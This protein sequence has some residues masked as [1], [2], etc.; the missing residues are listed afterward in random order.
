MTRIIF[1]NDYLSPNQVDID[2]TDEY[3][4][5]VKQGFSIE[6]LSFE[7]LEKGDIVK[8]CQKIK[9]AGSIEKACYR[10]WM[11]TPDLYELLYNHLINKNIQLINTPEEYLNCHYFPYY[12]PIIKDLTAESIWV[13]VNNEV[14][15][16]E[17]FAALNIF[18]N[19]AVILKDYVKSEKHYWHTACYIPNASDKENVKKISNTFLSLRGN[20]L[21]KGLVYREFL[22]LAH[23]VNHSQSDMPLSLEYRLFYFKNEL[24][25]A[26]EYWE[27]GEYQIEKPNFVPFNAL[28]KAVKSN[29]FTMDI[30]Q[31][32]NGDWIVMELGDGQVSGLPAR[33]NINDFYQKLKEKI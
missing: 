11:L 10:G 4:A 25:Y 29:F 13:A 8:A 28:A 16:D 3:N 33:V 20:A 7:A 12:Y 15:F 2:F 22:P 14:N 24:L 32:E 27:E 31:K 9:T 5:A 6:L 30:A 19:K 18:E 21:N 17:V 1:C 26:A 23:L